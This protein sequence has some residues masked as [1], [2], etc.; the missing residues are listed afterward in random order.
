[1]IVF[2]MVSNHVF[3]NRGAVAGERPT[4]TAGVLRST[5]NAT[6]TQCAGS[7]HK[8]ALL[9]SAGRGRWRTGAAAPS[10]PLRTLLPSPYVT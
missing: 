6:R 7:L 3:R 8:D 10:G 5:I 9:R 2:N 4:T 1:M